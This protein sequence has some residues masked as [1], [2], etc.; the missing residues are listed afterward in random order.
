MENKKKLRDQIEDIRLSLNSIK[1]SNNRTDFI[2][3]I[4]LFVIIFK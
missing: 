1:C 3:F 2:V 4:L